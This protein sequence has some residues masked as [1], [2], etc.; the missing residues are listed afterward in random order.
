MDLAPDRRIGRQRAIDY[1]SIRAALYGSYAP[2]T[3]GGARS[4][5]ISSSIMRYWFNFRRHRFDAFGD[6]SRCSSETDALKFD[7]KEPV[8][9]IVLNF[10]E[11]SII[12]DEVMIV[13][14]IGAR[15]RDASI[16]K[17][18]IVS[19]RFVNGASS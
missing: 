15:S 19:T 12:L 4:T 6:I 11:R 1:R 14:L 16:R 10:A 2:R 18:M 7:D 13:F 8:A 9:L 5:A 3:P 17:S